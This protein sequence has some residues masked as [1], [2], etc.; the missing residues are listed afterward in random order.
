MMVLN[1]ISPDGGILTVSNFGGKRKHAP[2]T[3]NFA[4]TITGVGMSADT[5]RTS[6]CA[7][8]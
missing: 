6:A 2:F 1:S 8:L 3:A 4:T 5:A 7:T